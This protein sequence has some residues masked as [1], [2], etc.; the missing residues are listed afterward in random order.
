MEEEKLINFVKDKDRDSGYQ[1]V[2]PIPEKSPEENKFNQNYYA[3]CSND[4]H[5]SN[6]EEMLKKYENCS[7]KF[8]DST[9]IIYYKTMIIKFKILKHKLLNKLTADYESKFGKI[10]QFQIIDVLRFLK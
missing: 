6:H 3:S 4:E 1:I 7:D 10:C 8:P 2:F 5:R 9:C